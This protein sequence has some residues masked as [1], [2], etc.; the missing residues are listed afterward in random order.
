MRRVERGRSFD[1]VCLSQDRQGGRPCEENRCRQLSYQ[2]KGAGAAT[3]N[4]LKRFTSRGATAR[5]DTIDETSTKWKERSGRREGPA[6]YV[7]GDLC[8]SVFRH[9][10]RMSHHERDAV[11][12]GSVI[13]VGIVSG[14][15]VPPPP[16]SKSTTCVSL[17]SADFRGCAPQPIIW[18]SQRRGVS[19]WRP[20]A[21]PAHRF[22]R[23]PLCP[24]LSRA[25]RMPTARSCRWT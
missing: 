16:G 17:L 13:L 20:Q 15:R 10:V 2:D 11:Y 14:R 24:C 25:A 5:D 22:P 12:G 6:T 23:L 8:L 18:R 4:V 9:V 1:T 3:M 21:P 19:L 7:A